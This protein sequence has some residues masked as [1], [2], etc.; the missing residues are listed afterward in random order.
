VGRAVEKEIFEARKYQEGG[1]L[2]FPR[3]RYLLPTY[4]KMTGF[5]YCSKAGVFFL[6]QHKTSSS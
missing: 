4:V 3:N 1:L 5:L 6:L 2:C